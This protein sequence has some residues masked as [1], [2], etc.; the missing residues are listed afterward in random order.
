MGNSSSSHQPLERG[1][2][3]GTYGDI[4]NVV[5]ILKFH[6]ERAKNNFIESEEKILC[7]TH[8]VRLLFITLYRI[9][10]V[11]SHPDYYMMWFL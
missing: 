7:M 6:I 9:F 3:R 1:F 5:C 4:K 2:T 11:M 8:I 10:A